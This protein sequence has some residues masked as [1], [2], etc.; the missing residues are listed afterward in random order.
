MMYI[1]QEILLDGQTRIHNVAYDSAA[2]ARLTVKELLLRGGITSLVGSCL[3]VSF[4][5]SCRRH[6]ASKAVYF[7]KYK[8]SYENMKDYDFKKIADQKECLGYIEDEDGYIVVLE[9]GFNFEAYRTVA[10]PPTLKGEIQKNHV[11]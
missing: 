11:S 7:H 5:R 8:I 10:K 2:E 3:I 1:L 6:T 4:K 9:A